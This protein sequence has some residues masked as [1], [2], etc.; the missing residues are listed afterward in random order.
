MM[1]V[2][3][4]GPDLDGLVIA[5]PAA[6]VRLLLP[7][8]GSVDLV[9]PTWNGN[10]FL[11]SD[12]TRPIIR[13]FT[14]RRFE[15]GIPELDLDM[16]IHDGGI[17]SAWAASA[18]IGS[19]AA[20]SGPGRGYTIDSAASEYVLG[21]D[22]TAIPAV[23]QLLESIPHV[24]PIEVHIETADGSGVIPMP[25]HPLATTTW[26]QAD[27]QG[28]PGAA[29]VRAIQSAE[30]AESTLVW[31]A[32]EAASMH[33]IRTHLFGKRGLPRSQATVRGYWKV[34]RDSGQGWSTD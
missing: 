24:I 20:I 33:Q 2:T 22:E 30:I 25:D 29:L 17:A 13:T 19:S 16:V 14:P 5:E 15:P 7:S 18:A 1:R 34:Q 10:E 4:S 23:S 6:S 11:L 21:G 3:L 27:G 12:G 26:H 32:G 9:T 31:C 28:P 8:P